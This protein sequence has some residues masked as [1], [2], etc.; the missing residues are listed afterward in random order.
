MTQQDDVTRLAQMFDL[1]AAE[2]RETLLAFAEFLVDRNRRPGEPELAERT[3]SSSVGALAQPAFEERPD[4]ETVSAALSRLSRVYHMLDTEALI[5]R[6]SD[7]LLSRDAISST[8]QRG[9]VDD[10]ERYFA[11]HYQRAKLLA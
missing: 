5:E 9:L 2:Q 8:S 10:L 6:A 3:G 11:E 7:E 4:D 1:L